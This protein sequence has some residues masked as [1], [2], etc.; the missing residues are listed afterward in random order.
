MLNKKFFR[1]T[2]MAFTLAGMMYFGSTPTYAQLGDQTLNEGMRHE[3]IQ[4]LQENLAELGFF[5]YDGLTTYYGVYTV[6]AVSN[7]Q[8]SV[9]L[10]PNGIFDANTYEA[11]MKAMD[12]T[13]EVK[14]EDSQKSE[15]D[16]K[17]TED[18]DPDKYKLVVNGSLK[19]GS[20]GLDV[21]AL[22]EVLRALGYLKIENTTN[23]FGEQTEEA[24]KILQENLG[25]E[26]DGSVGP[27]TVDVLNRLMLRRGLQISM[28]NR[29]GLSRQT[30][31][32]EIIATSKKYI[33]VRYRGGGT[34]PNGFDCT[35]YTQFVYKQHGISLPRDTA[36]QARV[37]SQLSK[38]DL[39]VGD[40]VI[41]KNTYRNG[42][43]HAGIYVGN[44]Q[45]I[46]ASTS[47]GVR[48][49]HMDDNYWGGR[50]HS[51]RRVF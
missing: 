48:V 14:T 36:S 45:F 18:D 6:E 4:T 40:L 44:G 28:P 11:L 42:P 37:G 1:N 41:F 49:D 43:S 20:T 2:V 32:Q 30:I 15:D 5:N 51:G 38:S 29:A 23:Y 8:N 25:L 39:Q 17:E 3:D 27:Q 47:R 31:G 46:H 26:V 24:V 21:N 7:F 22:Q 19:L 50:F 10:E 33:G 9:E 12:P 16:V 35:G 34:S 13:Y